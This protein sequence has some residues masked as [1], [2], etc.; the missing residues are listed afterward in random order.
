MPVPAD[1]TDFCNANMK[2]W[3]FLT[4][5]LQLLPAVKGQE[6]FLWYKLLWQIIHY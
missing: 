4:G 5:K 1:Q 2:W 6:D 3:G